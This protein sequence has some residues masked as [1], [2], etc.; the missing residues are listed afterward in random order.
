MQMA[1]ADVAYT[2]AKLVN[3]REGM[4]ASL[5]YRT[6]ERNTSGGEVLC[7]FHLTSVLIW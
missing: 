7:P 1:I 3:D 6:L 2:N 4:V 5:I